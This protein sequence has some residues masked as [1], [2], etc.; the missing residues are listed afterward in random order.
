MFWPNW[1]SSDVQFIEEA[2]G[3]L[4]RCYTW[5]FKGLKYFLKFFKIIFEVSCHERMVS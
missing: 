3:L 5:H 2:A 4:L 1:P